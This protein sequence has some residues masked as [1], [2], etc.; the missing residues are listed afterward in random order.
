MLR[1]LERQRLDRH[2]AER[3]GEHAALAHARRVVAA[4]KL[5]GDRGLDRPVEPHLLQVDVR[6]TAPHGMD[7]VLLENR[8][9]RL[10]FAVDLDVEDRVQAGRTGERAPELALGDADRD[11]LAVAVE[12]ARHEPLLAHTA[13]LGRA[14]P[15]ALRDHQFRP[16]SGHSGGGV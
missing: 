10:S 12:D 5:D 16:F 8:R 7:L 4:V 13:R 1:H 6:D 2:L 15:L 3:L 11:R 9:V 14:E